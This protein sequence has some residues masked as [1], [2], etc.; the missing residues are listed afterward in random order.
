MGGST[1]GVAITK[2]LPTGTNS[3]GTV[4]LDAGSNLIGAFR[5]STIDYSKI[6]KDAQ[7]ADASASA[8]ILWDPTAGKKFVVTDLIISTDVALIVDIDDGTDLIIKLYGGA[9]NTVVINL[10]THIQ[11]ATADNNLTF[12]TDGAGAISVTVTGYEV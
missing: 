11:S 9:D 8:V 1:S 2:A 4:G 3:I 10:Q 6:V 12:Q 5:K 7:S